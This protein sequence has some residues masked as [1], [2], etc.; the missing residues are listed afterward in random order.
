MN[1]LKRTAALLLACTMMIPAFACG[2]NN[3]SSTGETEVSGESSA[4]ES[5]AD[6]SSEGDSSAAD[7]K[8]DNSE[9]S[10]EDSGSNN[11]GLEVAEKYIVTDSNGQQNWVLNFNDNISV[12][13][14]E[15]AANAIVTTLRGDDGTIYVPKTDINGTT[16]TQ[17][18]GSPATELYTGTTLASKY[19]EP[20]YTPKFRNYMAL[21]LDISERK[22]FVFDG[23]LLEY[24][25]EI[26]D[27]APKGVYPIEFTLVD[28][29]DFEGKG[30]GTIDTNPGFVCVNMDEPEQN[31]TL[32]DNV[33][34]TIDT[35]SAKPGETAK[36]KVK[37]DNNTGIV[38]FRLMI[39]YDSNVITIKK[40]GAGKDLASFASL[41][42]RTIDDEA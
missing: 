32:S 2:K 11:A 6:N 25:L 34:L 28:I 17:E 40:S 13:N 35:I 22:D 33:T 29:S 27:D 3:S 37:I 26:A 5:N 21:W 1:N 20:T 8:S 7:S 14:D 10:S 19:E 9:N 41:T 24:Q 36:L 31:I 18:G 23:D 4:A 42:A 30:L 38:A 39:R 12:N 16:V 15:D